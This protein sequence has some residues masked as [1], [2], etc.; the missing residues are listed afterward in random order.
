MST[1]FI[2][3]VLDFE[4]TGFPPNAGV[5][6]IGWTDL[7]IMPDAPVEIS[8]TVA[9]LT[10]PGLPIGQKAQEVH[11]ITDAMVSD[12]PAYALGFRRAMEGA[13]A[14][15]SHNAEFEQNWFAGGGKPYLCTYKIALALSPELPN[16]KNGNLPGLLGIDL[17]LDRC[18]PL[19]RAGPDTYVTAMILRHYLGKAS[20][21]DLMQISAGARRITRMP[22]GKHQGVEIR[23]L[24]TE[25]MRWAVDNLSAKDVV[26][27]MKAELRARRA[28]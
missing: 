26:A 17:D 9:F 28:P 22:F 8:E 23:N 5:C 2:I 14:F 21:S 24:P 4:T 19:H 15:C 7:T 6:E 11:G 18:E 27:A 20:F 25:Y 13:D 3:R 10:N 16:H 1:P 12:A